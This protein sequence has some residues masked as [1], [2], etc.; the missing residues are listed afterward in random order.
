MFVQFPHPGAEHE[1]GGTWMDW[2]RRDHARKF[3]K[4]RG[5]YVSF[6]APAQRGPLVFWGEWEPQSRVVQT[7][8]NARPGYPRYLHEPYWMVPRHRTLL[9]NTDPLV[10]GKQFLYSNCRQARNQKLRELAPGSIVV[11]GSRLGA[12]FV[13]DTVFV[14]GDEADDFT[15]SKVDE[16]ACDDWVRDVVLRPLSR[17]SKDPGERFRLYRGRSYAEA[18]NE[19]YSFVPCLPYGSDADG[20]LRPA[21]RLSSRWISP[22]LA[23]GA[24]ATPATLTE[25]RYLWETLVEV[26]GRAGLVQGVELDVPPM[27]QQEA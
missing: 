16:L 11:F 17:S 19:P 26:V 21:L 25:L 12:A 24:K 18:P 9:Q 20:F 13:L 2:N 4:G 15:P 8:P 5:K 10:F 7:F 22:N 3:L 6:G 14:V 1:P 27:Q 23:Q